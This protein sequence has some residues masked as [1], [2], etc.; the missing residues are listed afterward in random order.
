MADCTLIFSSDQ[1][2][3]SSDPKGRWP[4]GSREWCLFRALLCRERVHWLDGFLIFP[5]WQKVSSGSRPLGDYWN[6]FHSVALK[7]A[8]SLKA[9]GL[10]DISAH[11]S[12]R[13]DGTF[14]L[15]VS[16]NLPEIEVLR[17][18]RLLQEAERRFLAG[19]DGFPQ[20]LDALQ[21]HWYEA[22]SLARALLAAK[23]GGA[24]A[25]QKLLSKPRIHQELT[26]Q[27]NSLL[28]AIDSIRALPCSHLRRAD[29]LEAREVFKRWF[30]DLTLV[31]GALDTTTSAPAVLDPDT[32]PEAAKFLGIA[33]ELRD[34]D[35]SVLVGRDLHI[36]VARVEHP[37]TVAARAELGK[38]LDRLDDCELV[39]RAVD[40]ALVQPHTRMAVLRFIR[41]HPNPLPRTVLHYLYSL[42]EQEVCGEL[43]ATT[44]VELED[45]DGEQREAPARVLEEILASLSNDESYRTLLEGMIAKADDRAP[46]QHTLAAK[47]GEIAEGVD[48]IRR[49]MASNQRAVAADDNYRRACNR[50]E[51]GTTEH[52]SCTQ[53]KESSD[54]TPG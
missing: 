41:L 27:R 6:N 52:S 9:R 47:V 2:Y 28:R 38:V 43:F 53:L 3:W 1:A 10:H 35:E 20:L 51:S 46:A 42:L 23:V 16:A 31:Q 34:I 29:P 48:A 18:V 40:H 36:A 5:S 44:L 26:Q 50:M 13:D 22:A 7:V 8:G 49:K 54:L 37:S 39:G 33:Q 14:H 11:A 30:E 17:H 15:D 19:D 4:V 24:L 12:T 21:A 32:D 45:A 25:A